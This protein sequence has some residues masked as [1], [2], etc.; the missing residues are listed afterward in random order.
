MFPKTGILHKSDSWRV[1]KTFLRGVFALPMTAEDEGL[2][3]HHTER[4]VPTEPFSEV[5]VVAGRRSGKSKIAA[6]TATYLA[7]F[8]DWSKVL[9]DGE[10]GTL[11]IIASDRRQAR[12]IFGY[13]KA[14]FRTPMLKSLVASSLKESIELTN[15]IRLE[16]HTCS[17][18][19]TR[20]YSLVAVVCDELAF[21]E[22]ESSTNPAGE[23]LNALRPGL[24]TTGGLLFAISS[25]F[26]KLGPLWENYRLHFGKSDSPILVWKGASLEMNPSL[27]PRVVQKALE[28]DRAAAS[29]E[30]LAQFR[31][32]V[33]GFLSVEEI[34]RSVVRGRTA[35]PCLAGIEYRAFVDPS[36]GRSDS[37]C[38]GIAHAEGQRVIL[39]LLREIHAPFS[40][41]QAV[42]DFASICKK[43]RVTEVN[44]DRYSA[45]WVAE[46]FGREGI[47]Y[48][49]ATKSRSELYLEFLPA[50][51]SG[52]LELLDNQ[53]MIA[54]FA[55]LQRRT[56]AG[57]DSVDHGT[58]DHDD[59]ANCAAG[60]IVS[61]L[62][63]NAGGLTLVEALKNF[64]SGARSMP[65]SVEDMRGRKQVNNLELQNAAAQ[66]AKPHCPSPGCQGPV[67]AL[68]GPGMHHCNSCSCDFKSDG[69]VVLAPNPTIIGVNCCGDAVEVFAKTGR[70]HRTVVSNETRC[71]GCGKQSGT[72]PSV[73]VNGAPRESRR[74]RLRRIGQYMLRS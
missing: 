32:D 41:Q 33:G 50:L 39:D 22:A 24:A 16:V 1:W 44:G 54:Q 29:A 66:K 58:G 15:N 40:P 12:V 67:I 2:W 38:L 59:L 53:R 60:C 73:P 25:P 63:A 20:G 69:T 34:E 68:G 14:F 51:T 28:R 7:A 18:K 31:D 65:A 48:V 45:E 74:D 35:L 57:R 49:A 6:L 71:L 64:D 19:A 36:G 30:Y 21:W 23:V 56:G 13:L 46:S 4:D 72:P 8:V 9:S 47:R 26:A 3:R 27:P 55:A 70:P 42:K 37:M 5:F 61:A 52:Q 11:P 62:S 17:F 10:V 43:Y